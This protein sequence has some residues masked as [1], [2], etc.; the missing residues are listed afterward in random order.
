MAIAATRRC[1]NLDGVSD[2]DVP[3]RL[4]DP[5]TKS[6]WP[7]VAALLAAVLLHAAL[8][9]WILW[10]AE[11]TSTPSPPVMQV[12]LVQVPPPPPPPPAPVPEAKPA[13][14]PPKQLASR[15]SGPGDKTTAPAPAEAKA[16]APEAPAPAPPAETPPEP[17]TPPPTPVPDAEA[18]PKPP[19]PSLQADEAP[20]PPPPPQEKPK[21]PPPSA[22]PRRTALA[23]RAPLEAPRLAE[24][25]L[26]E[27]AETGD[28]YLN[29]LWTRIEQHRPAT[30][31]IG[32]SGLHLEGITVL[33]VVI[34]RTGAMRQLGVVRSSG[35]PQLDEMA[36]QMILGAEPFPP[37]PSDY[38]DV[39]PLTVTI[40][41]YPQ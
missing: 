32:S 4:T 40:R 11:H 6:E 23:E 36:K 29:A 12:S 10:G 14:P 34:D 7:A 1:A 19:E 27:K 26:G 3:V 8:F 37:L 38:P 30:T 39:A 33:G 22:E 24:R 13:P 17:S 35:S 5:E 25:A 28:P 20:P 41:L 15:E 21:P 2:L 18:P 16:P 31:P 9:G